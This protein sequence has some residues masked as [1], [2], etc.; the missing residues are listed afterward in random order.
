MV[1]SIGLKVADKTTALQFKLVHLSSSS[2]AETAKEQ[3]PY[4]MLD[5]GI[6]YVTMKESFLRKANWRDKTNDKF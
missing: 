5:V 6:Y 4:D 3:Y 1:Y 2:N